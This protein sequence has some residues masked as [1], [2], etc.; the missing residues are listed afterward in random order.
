MSV[1]ILSCTHSQKKL[2]TKELQPLL[3]Y[4]GERSSAGYLKK[5]VHERND[6]LQCLSLCCLGCSHC[7]HKHETLLQSVF[8][9]PPARQFSGLLIPQANPAQT[10]L[11]WHSVAIAKPTQA[12]LPK[13]LFFSYHGLQ[14][15][16]N[17]GRHTNHKLLHSDH[18]VWSSLYNSAWSADLLKVSRIPL[19]FHS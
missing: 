8:L 10:F 17:I 1:F 2:K 9:L 19:C 13:L 14:T 3:F 16:G 15:D 11:P 18:V 12:H 6:F 5:T 7:Y 4:G